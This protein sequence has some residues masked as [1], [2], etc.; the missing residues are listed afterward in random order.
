[1]LGKA[2]WAPRTNDLVSNTNCLQFTYQPLII[3]AQQ[4]RLLKSIEI[5]NATLKYSLT[6][7]IST[8][9]YKIIIR[10]TL[11]KD[12]GAKVSSM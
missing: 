12:T 11:L 9:S 1:M 2:F 8:D 10:K 3:T 7:P 4:S 5:L 6:N